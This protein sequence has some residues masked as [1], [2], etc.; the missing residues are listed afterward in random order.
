M[1]TKQ[2]VERNWGDP[3]AKLE[4]IVNGNLGFILHSSYTTICILNPIKWNPS[5]VATEPIMGTSNVVSRLSSR[6]QP[7]ATKLTKPSLSSQLFP[8]KSASQSQLTS[9]SRRVSTTLRCGFPALTF[10]CGLRHEIGFS[11]SNYLNSIFGILDFVW[12]FDYVFLFRVSARLPVELGSF[13]SS[14]PLHSAVASARLVSSLSIESRGWGL[15]PQ[16]SFFYI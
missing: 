7:L 10:S 9:S 13:G 5:V 16:G 6:L 12:A 8:L 3:K 14:M 4:G 1:N 11:I 2:N 15:V